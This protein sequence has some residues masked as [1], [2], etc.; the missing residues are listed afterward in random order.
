ML[1]GQKNGV[2]RRIQVAEPI[3]EMSSFQKEELTHR[4]LLKKL[5]ALFFIYKK[6]RK[7]NH[8]SFFFLSLDYHGYNISYRE[9]DTAALTLVK[10]EK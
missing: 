4:G 3:L 9:T 8:L 5:F 2:R 6:K 7:E 10:L 1:S